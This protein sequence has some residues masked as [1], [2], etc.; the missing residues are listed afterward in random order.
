MV[1]G[2]DH[3]K[4]GALGQQQHEADS[5]ENEEWLTSKVKGQVLG[6]VW[7]SGTICDGNHRCNREI[8]SE[9]NS[10]QYICRLLGMSSIKEGAM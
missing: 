2:T 4:E 9:W 10:W 7:L 1:E 8:P 5:V 6:P 3:P